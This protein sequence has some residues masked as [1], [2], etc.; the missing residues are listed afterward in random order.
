[1]G[2][3]RP[4][5]G[6]VGPEFWDRRAARYADRV[7]GTAERDPFLRRVR[8]RC[9]RRT[10]VV[11]VGAGTGR[12]ALAL[13]PVVGRV[14]AVDQS[15]RM[16]ELLRGEADRR[17]LSNVETC[18]GRWE[19]VT[20]IVGDVVVCSYVLPVVTDV[21]AFIDKLDAAARRRV[22][23]YLSGA[24]ADL[25]HDH[26]W[27]HFH[28]RPR[29]PAPT[30]LDAVG[31]LRELGI[32][33]HVEVVEVPVRRRFTSVAEAVDDHHEHLLLNDTPTL[34]QELE[35]VLSIWLVR[36]GDRLRPP[37]KTLPGAVISWESGQAKQRPVDV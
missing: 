36:D 34:R 7:A 29:A 5:G 15:P 8:R 30:W 2:R 10:T 16:L 31:V 21:A 4:A 26:L 22:F 32:D 11:D 27:R 12:F 35:Q 17:G 14:I 24:S 37:L 13:A 33:P 28:G 20:G 23:V 3:L 1:M 6:D 25:V 9:G 19:D 18:H